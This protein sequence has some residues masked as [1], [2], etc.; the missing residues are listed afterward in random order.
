M[1]TSGN[2]EVASGKSALLEF[3]VASAVPM[4]YQWRKNGMHLSNNAVY[5]GAQRAIL[6]IRSDGGLSKGKYSCQ[7]SND[8]GEIESSFIYLSLKLSF[9]K[10]TRHFI[11]LYTKMDDIPKDSWPPVTNTEFIYLALIAKNKQIKDDYAYAVQGDMDDIIAAKENVEYEE[12]FARHENGTLLLVEG[13][14]GCGKTTLMHKVARD[15]AIKKNILMDA[16]IVVLVPLRLFFGNKRK[17][18]TLSNIFERYVMREA[19]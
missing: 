10:I 5:S 4:R 8:V 12:V 9:P 7:V 11:K 18:I 13:R 15:W 3:Q 19:N 6:F 2:T 16:E 14:P 1:Y 17:D